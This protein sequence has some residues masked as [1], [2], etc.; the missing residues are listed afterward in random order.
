MVIYLTDVD[1]I[2]LNTMDRIHKFS[3]IINSYPCDIDAMSHD[4]HYIVDAKS[5]MGIFSLDVSNPIV[6]RIHADSIEQVDDFKNKM[7]EFVA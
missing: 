5:I 1:G 3:D 7:K 4:N 6:V 2:L